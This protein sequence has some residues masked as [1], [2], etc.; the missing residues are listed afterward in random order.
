VA[1]I[2]GASR[3]NGIGIAGVVDGRTVCWLIAR[4]FEGTSGE[5]RGDNV[6]EGAEWLADNGAHVINLSLGGYF[7]KQTERVLY[8]DLYDRGV[9]IVA[10]SGNDGTSAKTF[11][12]SYDPVL[13][14]AAVDHRNTRAMFSQVRLEGDKL[15]HAVHES[16]DE[17]RSA[18]SI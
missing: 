3:G 8:Q 9:V 1:G 6:L 14:V 2:I 4:V 7:P 5:A 10:A 16:W 17:G 12:A 13:S 11:P 15:S 18:A